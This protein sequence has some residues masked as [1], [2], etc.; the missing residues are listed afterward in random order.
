M[1]T[2]S[3]DLKKKQARI[4]FGTG[5]NILRLEYTGT[6]VVT[7]ISR[8]GITL[9][10][11]GNDLKV[12]VFSGVSFVVPAGITITKIVV[13]S[14]TFNKNTNDSETIL[15]KVVNIPITSNDIL[16]IDDFGITLKGE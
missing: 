5:L 13:Y 8:E 12:G 3:M 11:Q 16:Y 2:T 4:V 14:P 15:E 1:S 9:T 7:P 6:G 10:E